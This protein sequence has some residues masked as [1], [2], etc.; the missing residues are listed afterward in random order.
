MSRVF[1]A[2]LPAF[3]SCNQGDFVQQSGR[4][5]ELHSTLQGKSFKNQGDFHIC[6]SEPGR[7]GSSMSWQF[8]SAV[9]SPTESNETCSLDFDGFGGG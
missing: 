9:L 4:C 5:L 6:S 8:T 2:G 3:A 7:V 1:S